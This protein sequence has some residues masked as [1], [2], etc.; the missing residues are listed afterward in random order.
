MDKKKT[1]KNRKNRAY[2]IDKSD[3]MQ[4]NTTSQQPTNYG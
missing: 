4:E 3:Y 1:R 2:E